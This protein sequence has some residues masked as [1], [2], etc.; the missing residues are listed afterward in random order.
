[1]LTL[2]LHMRPPTGSPALGLISRKIALDVA[3]GVYAPDVACHTP[4]MANIYPDL[5]SREFEPGASFELP[6]V[7]REVPKVE[8]PFRSESYYRTL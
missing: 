8:V 7:L 4:G 2:V 5:L 3:E 1:M 6:A